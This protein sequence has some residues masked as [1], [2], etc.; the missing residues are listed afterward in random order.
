MFFK[1]NQ[2]AGDVAETL[3]VLAVDSATEQ[4]VKDKDGN[5]KI[6]NVPQDLK[7]GE[8]AYPCGNILN[9]CGKGWKV[10][11]CTCCVRNYQR[12]KNAVKN[13]GARAVEVMVNGRPVPLRLRR[14][15]RSGVVRDETEEEERV[16]D[17][18]TSSVRDL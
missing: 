12:D 1:K 16:I 18:T 7:A 2:K 6:V 11:R 5:P 9:E 14:P 8:M 13:I 15:E 3:G 10:R 4:P 17:A